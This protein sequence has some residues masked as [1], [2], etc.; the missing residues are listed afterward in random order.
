MELNEMNEVKQN[1]IKAIENDISHFHPPTCQVTVCDDDDGSYDDMDLKLNEL[2]TFTNHQKHTFHFGSFFTTLHS[3]LTVSSPLSLYTRFLDI[4][5]RYFLQLQILFFSIW[6]ESKTNFQCSR[7]PIIDAEKF[8][9]NWLTGMNEP[10]VRPQYWEK[11][12]GTPP[13]TTCW[14]ANCKQLYSRTVC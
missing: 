4:F 7:T 14:L 3:F 8:R 11:F 6:Q 13:T 5:F 12:Q 1:Q 10:T 9:A 2:N